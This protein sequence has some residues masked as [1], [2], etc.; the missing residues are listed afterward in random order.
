[1]SQLWAVILQSWLMLRFYKMPNRSDF[2]YN[3]GL[4]RDLA[5]QEL[6]ISKYL[7]DYQKSMRDQT[8]QVVHLIMETYAVAKLGERMG[9]W[10]VTRACFDRV[11]FAVIDKYRFGFFE[12]CWKKAGALKGAE[13][14]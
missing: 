12:K 3:F 1:M 14:V 4:D 10:Q 13:S 9:A 7:P 8:G 2:E 5:S 11:K 6:V